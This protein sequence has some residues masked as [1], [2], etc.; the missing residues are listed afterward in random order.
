MAVATKHEELIAWQLSDELK[1]RITKVVK[2]A[3]AAGDYDF[4]RQI[5]KSS[6]SAPAL[7]AEGFARFRDTEFARYL[8]MAL[9][10]LGETRNQLRDAAQNNYV[11]GEEYR[12]LWHLCYRASRASSKLL[13]SLKRRIEEEEQKKRKRAKSKDP[14]PGPEANEDPP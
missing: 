5:R 8:E 7:I 10:S 3:R 13:K 14:K 1:S 2:T 6:R 11:A 12:D 9:G 4:C